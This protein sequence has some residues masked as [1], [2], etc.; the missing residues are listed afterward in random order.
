VLVNYCYL[1]IELGKV[2]TIIRNG[3]LVTSVGIYEAGIAIDN[4]KIVQLSHETN[5]PSAERTI[6]AKGR[7]VFPGMI[8]S[9]VHILQSRA[10]S[11]PKADDYESATR[12]AVLGGVTTIFDYVIQHSTE[13]TPEEAINRALEKSRQSNIDFAYHMALSGIRIKTYDDLHNSIDA[14]IEGG[15]TSFKIYMDYKSRGHMLTN[16]MLYDAIRYS[17]RKGAIIQTHCEDGDLADY[18]DKEFENEVR[19]AEYC[20]KNWPKH[21]PNFIEEIAINTILSIAR[22]ANAPIY[23]VH[24]TTKDGLKSIR[25]SKRAGQKVFVEVCC[26][27]L[28]ISMEDMEKLGLYA[29]TSPPYR[30]KEDVEALW[31]GIADGTIDVLSTD[32]VAPSKTAKDIGFTDWFKTAGGVPCVEEKLSLFY[33]EAV[34]KRNL[35][36]TLL[37]RLMCENPSKIWGLYPKK[38]SFIV[39]ADADIVLLDPKEERTIRAEN[40]KSGAGYTPFEGW[41]VRGVPTL[42]MLRGKILM[43][44]SE[45]DGSSGFGKYLPLEPKFD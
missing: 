1:L 26:P 15:I 45:F 34:V 19:S 42:T 36:P 18:F 14:A 7:L 3:K 2:D 21:R 44:D 10:D 24:L 35:S 43:E 37:T 25:D 4:G 20:I 30:S 8:D 40:M 23:I 6:D 9:H 27:Y 39:G 38:G 17:K 13:K 11:P 32:H 28:F 31:Q 33:N 5:L 22:Y 16:D 41:K 29:Y 12:A